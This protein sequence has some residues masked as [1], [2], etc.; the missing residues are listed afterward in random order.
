[1]DRC[2][3]NWSRSRTTLNTRSMLTLKKQMPLSNQWDR[4]GGMSSFIATQACLDLLLLSVLTWWRKTPGI[5]I[6]LCSMWRPKGPESDQIRISF[7][8]SSNTKNNWASRWLRVFSCSKNLPFLM[9]V[10]LF[11]QPQSIWP[12]ISRVQL[13]QEAAKNRHWED[14]V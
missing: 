5:P 12:T 3:A 9:K 1:M 10:W 4:V 7:G 6:P 13:Y 2:L 14:R 8:C 11:P